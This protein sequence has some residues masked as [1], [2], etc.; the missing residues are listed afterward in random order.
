MGAIRI[1]KKCCEQKTTDDF[2]ESNMGTCKE[3]IKA[4][5]KLQRELLIST[6]E[7]LEKERARH[8]E[9]Y[10]RLGYKEQQKEWN[11]NKPWK[12][13]TVY[14]GLRWKYYKDL[15]REFEL[16]HW[17]YN[18]YYLLDV[19]IL[20]IKEHKNLHNSLILDL[21]K[22]IFYLEDGTYLDTK[23]KHKEYI[24]SLNINIYIN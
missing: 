4:K 23:E 10:H 20:N 8:R 3:C 12:E 24:E 18:D 15:P 11:K 19:F 1:C 5:A 22:R 7:G 21:E 13:S 6:P 14:K 16:H 2:Y 17:N 9:K